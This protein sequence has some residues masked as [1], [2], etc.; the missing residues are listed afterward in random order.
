MVAALVAE[1]APDFPGDE[2]VV[3]RNR[4]FGFEC[5]IRLPKEKVAAALKAAKEKNGPPP[6]WR[7]GDVIDVRPA[8]EGADSGSGA[9]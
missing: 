6:L 5:V 9:G 7:H 2:L 4:V 1:Y 8:R 3:Y